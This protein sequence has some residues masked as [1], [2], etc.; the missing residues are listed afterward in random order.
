VRRLAGTYL[1]R[2]QAAGLQRCWSEN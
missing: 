2:S 1:A